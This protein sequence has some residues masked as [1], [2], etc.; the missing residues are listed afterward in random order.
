MLQIFYKRDGAI[1]V[2]LSL[3]LL[4]VMLFGGIATDAARTCQK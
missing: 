3:I 4:P 2:F 1:S